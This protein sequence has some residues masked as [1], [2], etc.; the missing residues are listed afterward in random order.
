[1]HLRFDCLSVAEKDALLV[2]NKV[3]LLPHLDF[4]MDRFRSG[5]EA[6]NDDLTAFA[7]SCRTGEGM[8]AWFDWLLG[9]IEQERG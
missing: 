4:D 1:M 5:V 9:L 7:M 3:D 8:E 2:L 6:L